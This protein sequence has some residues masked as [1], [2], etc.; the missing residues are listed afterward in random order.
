MT[1]IKC[2]NNLSSCSD[3]CEFHYDTDCVIYSGDTIYCYLNDDLYLLNGETLTN[4]L[5]RFF[6][7]ICNNSNNRGEI[8]DR[9]T[10][11]QPGQDGIVIQDLY[12][13]LDFSSYDSRTFQYT[14]SI[15]IEGG[16][17]P[18][19]LDSTIAPY[20][21]LGNFIIIG[22]PTIAQIIVKRKEIAFPRNATDT[23]ANM[24][25]FDNPSSDLISTIDEIHVVITDSVGNKIKPSIMVNHKEIYNIL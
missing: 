11:G 13:Q 22:T 4:I 18:Y 6:K 3:G 21:A 19:V 25:I 16:T 9:G 7:V 23:P 1:C 8:G 15:T 17:A 10:T 14:Y 24:Q 5:Q 20:L 2:Q 12:A